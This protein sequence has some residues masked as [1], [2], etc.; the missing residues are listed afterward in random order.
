M[1]EREGAGISPH[2]TGKLRMQDY[3]AGRNDGLLLALR[4]LREEGREALEKEC[5][6]RRRTGI[7]TSVSVKELSKASEEILSL[8]NESQILLCLSVLHDEFD[9][10]EKR[11]NQAMDA[12]E[13]KNEAF[14]GDLYLYADYREQ[15]EDTMNRVIKTP[16]LDAEMEGK[17]GKE[18]VARRQ[19]VKPEA[20]Q[21][22]MSRKARLK[23][24]EE[25][26]KKGGQPQ[27]A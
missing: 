12:W 19:P 14:R 2:S 3:Q 26:R 5:E 18:G 22:K 11:L 15:L 24:R 1:R 21:R 8:V 25:M 7:F 20:R 9:F 27:G 17:A 10:G 6:F 4:I 23:L 13:E 16:A